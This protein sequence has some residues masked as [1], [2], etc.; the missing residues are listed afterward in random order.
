MSHKWKMYVKLNEF[1]KENGKSNKNHTIKMT[2]ACRLW[3][4]LKTENKMYNFVNLIENA[5]SN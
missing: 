1:E 3:R 2:N 4:E 5:N